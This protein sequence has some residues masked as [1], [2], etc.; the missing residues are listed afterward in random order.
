MKRSIVLA[1]LL[2]FVS[3]GALAQDVVKIEAQRVSHHRRCTVPTP[4]AP[5]RR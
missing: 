2:G 4:S 3:G 5:D 1:A